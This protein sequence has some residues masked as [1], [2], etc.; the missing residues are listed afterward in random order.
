MYF[1]DKNS[2]ILSMYEELDISPEDVECY[3][4]PCPEPL[5]KGKAV[6]EIAACSGE[7]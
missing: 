2:R 5:I 4:E 7:E 3:Q 1:N 6:I